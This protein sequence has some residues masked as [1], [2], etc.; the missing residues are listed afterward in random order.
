MLRHYP[1]EIFPIAQANGI[2]PFTQVREIKISLTKLTYPNQGWLMEQCCN[3]GNVV[4]MHI[5]ENVSRGNV[6]GVN[7]VAPYQKV[8]QKTPPR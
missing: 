1:T 7:D 8:Y 5:G 2:S 6:G 4:F 3:W